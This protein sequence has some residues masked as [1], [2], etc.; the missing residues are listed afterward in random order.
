MA[1]AQCKG[2]GCTWSA[3]PLSLQGTQYHLSVTLC[4][5]HFNWVPLM[6]QGPPCVPKLEGAWVNIQ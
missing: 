6:C 4:T 2:D 3:W 1:S 5:K